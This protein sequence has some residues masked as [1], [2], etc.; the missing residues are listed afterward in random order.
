MS[1]SM[2]ILLYTIRKKF[3]G[4]QHVST[5]TVYGWLVP[6]PR[7]DLLL[8]DTRSAAEF[9]VSRLPGAVHLDPDSDDVT[10]R[11]TL[12][13]HL[14]AAAEPPTT[15]ACYCSVGYR[16]SATAQRLNALRAAAAGSEPLPSFEAV[17]IEGSLFKWANEGK[18]LENADGKTTRFA[19]P[20]DKI[21]GRLLNKDLWKFPEKE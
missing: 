13:R 4:V 10:V 21:F 6:R 8:L 19:H 3:S 9:G 2:N 15:I 7:A 14:P 11:R 20:Y 18:P 5:D 1:A 17:N 12:T 16:S